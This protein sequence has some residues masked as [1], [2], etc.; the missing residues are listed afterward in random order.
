M[1]SAS[2]AGILKLIHKLSVS[3]L[4]PCGLIHWSVCGEVYAVAEV[5]PLSQDELRVLKAL[6]RHRIRF[7]IVGLS[8]AALQRAPVVTEDVDLWIEDLSDPKFHAAVQSVGAAYI[9]PFGLHNPP[10]LAG[11]GAE[12]FDLVIRM[13][14]L[15]SFAEEYK[16]AKR[17][18][19]AGH[20]FKVLPLERIIA[21]KKAANRPKDQ[22]VVPVLIDTLKTLNAPKPRRAVKRRA[23]RKSE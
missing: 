2:L 7:L 18:K 13:S 10:M 17:I 21:S 6:A 4:C 9:P 1:W 19:I 23:K 5:L 22:L 3:F 12:P 14:G 15:R 8:A 16:G 11:C 20:V